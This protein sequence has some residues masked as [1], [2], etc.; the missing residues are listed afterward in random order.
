MKKTG[1]KVEREAR[2]FKG[3][4]YFGELPCLEKVGLH[5]CVCVYLCTG[6]EYRTSISLD[7]YS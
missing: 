2:W 4:P 5:A 7:R 3:H 1:T 6:S